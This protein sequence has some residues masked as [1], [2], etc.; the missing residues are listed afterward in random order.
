M[1]RGGLMRYI[2]EVVTM[3][4][5]A[6][7]LAEMYPELYDCYKQTYG[8][9]RPS[10]DMEEKTDVHISNSVADLSSD[11]HNDTIYFFLKNGKVYTLDLNEA[12]PGSA[13]SFGGDRQLGAD[14]ALLTCHGTWSGKGWC[15]LTVYPGMSKRNMASSGSDLNM[16]EQFTLLVTRYTASFA[17]FKYFA[18]PFN[19]WSDNVI[20]SNVQWRVPNG[21]FEKEWKKYLAQYNNDKE[22]MYRGILKQLAQKGLVKISSSGATQVT[23]EGKNKALEYGAGAVI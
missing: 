6:K 19:A 14:D 12:T 20:I 18:N 21:V 23:V 2:K 1:D 9:K 4:I 17:R 15:E 11:Y 10:I 16:I 7:D 3:V 5:T 22:A 13:R 8:S